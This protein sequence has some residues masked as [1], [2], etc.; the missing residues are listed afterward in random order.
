[1]SDLSEFSLPDVTAQLPN[2]HCPLPDV[3]TGGQPAPGRFVELARAGCRLVIDLRNP[4]E[5]RGFDERSAAAQHGM[6]YVNLPVG[7]E[8]IS[9]EVFDRFRDLLRDP[10]HRPALVHCTTANRVGAMLIPYLVLDEGHDPDAAV[11]LASRVGLR[12]PVL[13]R[14]AFDYLERRSASP[15]S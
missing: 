3:A 5:P 6:Q 12:S 8:G 15:G 13:A 14:A 1:M 7:Y 9:H 10:E 4:D 2:G 11:D